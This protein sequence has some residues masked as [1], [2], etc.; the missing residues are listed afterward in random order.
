MTTWFVTRHPGA[1]Q[2]ARQQRLSID[3][4]CAHLDTD[5]LLP[6]DTVF[7]TLPVHLAAQVC[8]RSARFYNLSLD[9]PPGARG[10]ELTADDLMTYSARLEGY[11]VQPRH[12]TRTS[13]P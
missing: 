10:R 8:A 4:L 5:A 11:D 2:W 9:L 12:L 1:L 13:T 3:R 6:G 7:G